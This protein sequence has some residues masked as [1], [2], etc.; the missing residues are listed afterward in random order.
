MRTMTRAVRDC[1]RRGG[2]SIQDLRR[3]ARG[4]AKRVLAPLARRVTSVVPADPTD[5][6]LAVNG[7]GHLMWGQRDLVD[8]VREFGSPLHVINSCVVE[9]AVE[10][11]RDAGIDNAKTRLFYSYKTNPVPGLL[12]LLDS[13][14]IGAEVVSHYE[15][16]LA[17]S[18]DVSPLDIVFNGPAKSSEAIKLAVTSGVGMINANSLR[19]LEM[20]ERVAESVG[21][22]A[23]VG[24]RVALDTTWGGQ[25]GLPDGDSAFEAFQRVVQSPYLSLIGLHTHHGSM[26]ADEGA[27]NAYL[28]DVF[29]FVDALQN[30]GVVVEVLDLGGSVPARTTYPIDPRKFRMNRALGVPLLPARRVFDLA[31][32][33]R[34]ARH[35]SRSWA[36][37]RNQSEP[38]LYFEPGRGLTGET[39]L[40]LTT[41]LDILESTTGISHAVVDAGVNIANPLPWE[42]HQLFSVSTPSRPAN[43]RYRIVGPTCSPGDILFNNWRLPE[44]E[45]GDLLAIMDTGAYFIPYANEFSFPR[46]AVVNLKDSRCRIWRRRQ[47]FSDLVACDD[48]S[49]EHRECWSD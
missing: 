11:A 42:Y 26:I 23:N 32:F 41:V 15:L 9:S 10:R 20:I 39:Q 3:K 27:A 19:E 40:T 22:V 6:G 44:L 30:R 46:P 35:R 1:H 33:V 49:L 12:R 2:V 34:L 14:D 5:W 13:L 21:K 37:D 8:L 36:Q 38:S 18:L 7:A 47:I 43:S 4:K 28:D 17:M 45:P 16:W 29:R 31:A 24:I 25:F 48:L